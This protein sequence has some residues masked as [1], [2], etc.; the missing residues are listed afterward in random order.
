MS[1]L[2]RGVADQYSAYDVLERIRA[3]LVAMGE[4]P[5]HVHPDVLKNVDEFHIGGAEAT[6]HLL[7][8]LDIRPETRVLDIGSGIGGPARL[9]AGRFGASVTGVDL[10]PDFVAT[11]EALTGMCGMSDR[12]AFKVGSATALPLDD[13]AFNLAL[14]L[15][16]GMN[17]PDKAAV[18]REAR[19]VLADGGVFA[20][21][22][23]MR[24]GPGEIGYPV[25]WADSAAISSVAAPKDYRDMAGKA[26]FT[27]DKEENRR[28]IALDFF[29]RIQA[30]VQ[31]SAPP[32]LGLHNLMGA[33]I[34][35]KMKNMIAAIK[36]GTIAPVQMIFHAPTH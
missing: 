1:D 5:D 23:V 10:T 34:G 36:A 3:G 15:H 19:R 25:P 2:E 35:D 6:A 12:V 33:S 31:K 11:A 29:S 24:I 26:G 27:L 16:V 21:Y 20:V 18:F 22:D 14:M 30:A 9:V 17:I 8:E 28:D 7:D 13:G 32:P 4:D